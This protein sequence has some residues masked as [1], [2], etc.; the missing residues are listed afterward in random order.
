M[1]IYKNELKIIKF[2]SNY[3]FF[4]EEKY[5]QFKEYDWAYYTNIFP[6]PPPSKILI[7]K[8]KFYRNKIDLDFDID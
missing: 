8:K 7:Y 3:L 1:P 2:L 6:T 5:T 4:M